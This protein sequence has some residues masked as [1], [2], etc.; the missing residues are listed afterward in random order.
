MTGVTK[1]AL[2]AVEAKLALHQLVADY[3][4]ELDTTAGRNATLL[5]T[6]DCRMDLGAMQL[7]GH[8]EIA[9]FYEGFAAKVAASGATAR[10][11]RH[12]ATNLRIKLD[13]NEEAE[14][15]FIVLNFSAPGVAP[16]KGGT[17]PTILSDVRM[18]CRRDE[19]RRWLIAQMGGG[20]VFIGDDPLQNAAL[21]G[22]GEDGTDGS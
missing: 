8:D 3:C 1:A 12:V 13:G 9:R 20:P 6:D 4:L 10:T 5:M 22:S 2:S 11:T 7:S 14:V 18:R 17:G 15:D 21:A 19:D 16:L